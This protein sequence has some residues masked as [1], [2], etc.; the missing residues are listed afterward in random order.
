M[1]LVTPG[2]WGGTVYQRVQE[3]TGQILE[4]YGR[5]QLVSFTAYQH[6]VSTTASDT[7]NTL[8]VIVVESTFHHHHPELD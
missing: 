7:S 8:S 6:Q 3:Q 1:E 2:S 5:L 4:R